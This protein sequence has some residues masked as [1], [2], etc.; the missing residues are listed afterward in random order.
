[1]STQ[2]AQRGI[3]NHM[4]SLL[5][6][7]Y[8]YALIL[9]VS[10][11]GLALLDWRHKLALFVAPR[12]TVITV[13]LTVSFFLCWDVIGILLRIFSTNQKYVSGLH[14]YSRDLPI[15]EVGFLIML[16]YVVLL[17][18]NYFDQRRVRHV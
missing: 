15:E 1:M 14:M 9:S 12:A 5:T 8:A 2:E 16:S 6:T 3:I 10:L 11:I 18:Y 4:R 13:F 7:P 17:C